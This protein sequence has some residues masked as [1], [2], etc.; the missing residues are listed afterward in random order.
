VSSDFDAT[1]NRLGAL[2][3]RLSDRMQM[4]A[5]ADGAR[6]VSAA[7]AL[8]VLDRWFGAPP[9]VDTLRRVLGLT[10]SG[11]VRLLDVLERDGLVTRRPGV[12]GRV[13][14]VV[15]TAKGRRTARAAITGRRLLLEET[16]ASLDP[17]ER[18]ALATIVDKLL[19]DLVNGP[20][21]DAA[22]CRL[23]DTEA[24][25]AQRDEPCP[26]TLAALS[27]RQSGERTD[28]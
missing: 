26:I 5:T 28:P 9:S 11:G 20:R 27:E 14:A 12:D 3:L 21:P 6:S 19:I 2:A 4:T 13:R 15:L 7:T 18:D 16:L 17:A 1:A 24:C 22:M 10:P 23:C 25:G 8:S